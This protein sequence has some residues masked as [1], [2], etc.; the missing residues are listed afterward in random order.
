MIDP[1]LI[2]VFEWFTDLNKTRF[3]YVGMDFAFAPLQPQNILAYMQLKQIAPHPIEFDLL[4]DVD[5]IYLELM[6]KKEAKT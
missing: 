5:S 3:N 2:H 4:C 6:N 1:L